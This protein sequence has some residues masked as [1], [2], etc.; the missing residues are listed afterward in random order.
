MKLSVLVITLNEEEDIGDCLESVKWADEIVV[1]DSGSTDRTVAIARQY[2]DRVIDR[3]WS[4]YTAQRNFAIDSATYDWVLCLD[5]DERLSAP[6]IAEIQ[7]VVNFDCAGYEMPRRNFFLGQFIRYAGW[8]PDYGVRLFDRRCGRFLERAVHE[9]LQIKGETRRLRYPIE[10]YTYRSLSDYHEKSERYAALGA[11]ELHRQMKLFSVFDLV[12][13]SAWTFF[14]TYFLQQGFRDGVY[15][16]LLSGLSS[17]HTF[18]KYAKLWEIEK[19]NKE[20]KIR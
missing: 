1:V 12:G 5:A 2:T 3:P 17:H 6:L 18:L 14:R 8:Y 15:G 4:G 13:H 9:P 16:L 10:H 20:G 7:A 19:M 11:L